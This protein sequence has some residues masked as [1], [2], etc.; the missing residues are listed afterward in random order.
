MSLELAPHYEIDDISRQ[1]EARQDFGRLGVSLP[2]VS[3]VFTPED[4]GSLLC[5]R[6]YSISTFA[7]R[8]TDHR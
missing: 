4:L 5:I 1:D 6:A 3:V 8:H 2:L 7:R